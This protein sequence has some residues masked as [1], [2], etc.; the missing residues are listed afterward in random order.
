M[1]T[2]FKLV[3]MTIGHPFDLLLAQLSPVERSAFLAVK[4]AFTAP[5]VL[6]RVTMDIARLDDHIEVIDKIYWTLHDLRILDQEKT[7]ARLGGEIP[8]L[9]LKNGSAIEFAWTGKGASEA[10]KHRPVRPAS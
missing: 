8:T 9:E 6:V 10:P 3:D 5:N 1:G 2:V 4:H 7:Q